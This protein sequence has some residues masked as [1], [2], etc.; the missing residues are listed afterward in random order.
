MQKTHRY[1][2]LP[3]SIHFRSFVS[4]HPRLTEH[5]VQLQI[6]DKTSHFNGFSHPSCS[7]AMTDDASSM[8]PL[9]LRPNDRY[10]DSSR[11]RLDLICP[12]PAPTYV[13]W[14]EGVSLHSHASNTR[15]LEQQK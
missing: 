13:V 1:C 10:G 4:T 11:F 5:L 15:I 6:V 7:C 14:R 9:Q 3:A 2:L 12:L 8:F